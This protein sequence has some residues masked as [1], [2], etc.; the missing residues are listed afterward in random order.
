[1]EKIAYFKYKSKDGQV[2]NTEI[3]CQI[4]DEKYE[5]QLRTPEE[6]LTLRA[7]LVKIFAHLV[8]ESETTP[9]IQE[10]FVINR[11]LK[12]EFIFSCSNQEFTKGIGEFFIILSG[13]SRSFVAFS[14]FANCFCILDVCN[15]VF[16]KEHVFYGS[17]IAYLEK[18]LSELE[19][20]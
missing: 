18:A 14:K 9:Y 5:L 8:N 4:A 13:L 1:M 10:Y 17:D 15:S 16:T 3:E 2:W 6:L 11:N 7:I 20:K 19:K 12:I